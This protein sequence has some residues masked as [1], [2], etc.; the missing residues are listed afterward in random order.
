MDS[1]PFPSTL[2]AELDGDAK[3]SAFSIK[4]L[5]VNEVATHLNRMLGNDQK[6]I[7]ISIVAANNSMLVGGSEDMLNKAAE[8]IKLIDKPGQ[9]SPEFD[10]ALHWYRHQ[11][12][13]P[14]GVDSPVEGLPMLPPSPHPTHDTLFSDHHSDHH[15]HDGKWHAEIRKAEAEIAKQAV[16]VRNRMQKSSPSDAEIDDWRDELETAVN[17]MFTIR[18]DVQR[19]QLEELQRRAQKIEER[20]KEREESREEFVKRRV[21]SLLG[22]IDNEE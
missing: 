7:R 13:V 10:T 5:P 2:N 12:S 1:S 8:I 16:L 4:H 19:Q 22:R 6:R 15:S 14:F 18:Q 20:L 21:E 11:A 9:R 3:F 17:R